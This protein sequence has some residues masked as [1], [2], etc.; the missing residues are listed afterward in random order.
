MICR[1]GSLLREMGPKDL[2]L[3]QD[4]REAILALVSSLHQGDPFAETGL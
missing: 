2:S 1:W 3:G 4:R